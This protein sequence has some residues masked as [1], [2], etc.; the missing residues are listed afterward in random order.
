MLLDEDEGLV[1]TRPDG[2][3]GLWFFGDRGFADFVLR[4][5]FRIDAQSDNSGVFV[6]FRD[7][8]SAPPDPAEPR[9]GA[10]PAWSAVHTGFEIQVDD[11]ARGDGAD[12]RRTGALYDIATNGG[13]TTQTYSRGS[14]LRPGAWNDLEITVSGDSFAVRL[15]DHVTSVFANADPTR[16]VSARH[17]P[18]S[19]FIGLQ[20]HTG[21]VSFR[22]VRLREVTCARTTRDADLTR[23]TA[24]RGLLGLRGGAPVRRRAVDDGLSGCRVRVVGLAQQDLG[25]WLRGHAELVEHRAGSLS[26]GVGASLV[27]GAQCGGD[28]ET[29]G[30]L[31]V[32][33]EV[34]G[35]FGV[36]SR[37]VGVAADQAELAELQQALQLHDADVFDLVLVSGDAG[38]V[39]EWLAA[40]PRGRRAEERD[41][42]PGVALTTVLVGVAP[43]PV[44]APTG[45]RG[46]GRKDAA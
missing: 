17:D 22:A 26:H 16:G 45:R 44:E 43:E 9:L 10:N 41:R 32:G 36:G 39:G 11:L 37:L 4:L 13:P 12:C 24:A 19:G 5:Q 7:P 3:I 31:G 1:T 35:S 23:A 14:A 38:K 34:E 42:A 27:V 29:V 40:P 2:D 6:R 21:N 46:G 25:L 15:N 20:Q 18:S 28:G 30:S 8:R 33:V